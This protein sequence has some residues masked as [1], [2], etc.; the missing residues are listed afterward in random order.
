MLDM[1]LETDYPIVQNF[2][3]TDFILEFSLLNYDK[4]YKKLT[5]LQLQLILFS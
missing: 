4:K 1:L 2:A 5:C 3:K